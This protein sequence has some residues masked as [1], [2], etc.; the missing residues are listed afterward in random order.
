[1]P[2]FLKNPR[3]RGSLWDELAAA[4]VIEPRLVKKSESLWLDVETAFGAAYGAVQ[5][6]DRSLAPGATPVTVVLDMDFERV[7]GIYR[8]ALTAR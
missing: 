3:A 7:L 5:P 6:L 8:G 4:Y 2:G 1:F